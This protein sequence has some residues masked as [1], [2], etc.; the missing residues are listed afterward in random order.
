MNEQL[1]L[2]MIEALERGIKLL[3]IIARELHKQNDPPIMFDDGA[4][5]G[6]GKL[7]FARRR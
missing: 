3:E 5:L 4:A 1:E 2:R 7:N 6:P